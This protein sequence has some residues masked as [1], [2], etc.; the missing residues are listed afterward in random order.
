MYL[1]SIIAGTEKAKHKKAKEQQKHMQE[2]PESE[3]VQSDFEKSA[4][5]R[6][7]KADADNAVNVSTETQ[8]LYI[9]LMCQFDK[10]NVLKYLM[11]Q[12]NYPLEAAIHVCKTYQ[13]TEA[14][15]YLLERA[16]DISGA[17]KLMKQV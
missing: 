10:Q 1:A 12:D 9:K 14:V 11:S 8:I 15:I 7:M 16:G 4:A 6:E 17:M 13:I 3:S 5:K 2:Q